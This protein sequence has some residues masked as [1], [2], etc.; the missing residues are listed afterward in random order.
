VAR[1]S[2]V[3][4]VFGFVPARVVSAAAELGLADLLADGPRTS[5]ELAAEAGLHAPS[6]RRL[7]RLLA[8][9]GVVAQTEADRFELTELGS[10]LRS[11]VPE[12]VRSFLTML[13]DDW[14]WQSWGD[15]VESL[16]TGEIA[17]DRVMGMPL[18]DYLGQH[19][20]KG[21]LFNKAMSDMTRTVAPGVVAG[22][23]F[24]P[25]ETVVDVGGGNG[26]LLA[27]ILE[28]APATRGVL[29]DLP[30]VLDDAAPV[31]E[32]AGVADR[33]ELV[34]GDF[35]ESVPE[36]GDAYL[37]KMVL[38]DWD[39]EKAVTIL[40]NCRKAV[41][42]DGKVLVVERIVPEIVTPASIETL[43]LDVFML[44]ALG[45]RERTAAEYGELLAQAD[46]ELT[47]VTEPLTPVGDCLI[48][49]V[50]V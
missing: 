45:G 38:H 31:L 41:V 36:G 4:L 47:R 27:R 6:V 43:I 9:L 37:M 19:P 25:F 26:T 50:P 22:Y 10:T 15:L 14:S 1:S 8:V 21:A 11:D 13:C 7:L 42:P 24:S 3:E 33:C 48:E 44:V 23:D 12:S 40:R 18:F 46:L 28:A 16:R 2:L 49:A 39:D 20:E 17:V 30:K 35:F 5:E 29:F 34:G 32:A